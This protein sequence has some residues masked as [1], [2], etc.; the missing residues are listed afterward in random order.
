MKVMVKVL[1]ALVVILSLGLYVAL[2]TYRSSS[3]DLSEICDLYGRPVSPMVFLMFEID[4]LNSPGFGWM[5][6]D[7]ALMVFGMY[8][9]IR[10]MLT[11]ED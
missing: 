8:W 4:S 10:W 9:G 1:G 7:F 2:L 3:G 6:F 5:L 11:G